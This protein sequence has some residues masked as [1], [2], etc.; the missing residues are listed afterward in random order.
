MAALA[1]SLLAHLALM[2]EVGLRGLLPLTEPELRDFPIEAHLQAPVAEPVPLPPKARVPSPRPAPGPTTSPVMPT[3]PAPVPLDGTPAA[4]PPAGEEASMPEVEPKP[5]PQ[6]APAPVL[7]QPSPDSVPPTQARVRVLP[8]ALTLVYTIRIGDDGF[9][10]GR[11]TYTWRADGDRYRL[12]SVAEATGLAALF[13]GGLATQSSEGRI[14]PAGLVPELFRMSR[15]DRR[16]E[17]A[18]F[19]WQAQR[20][21]LSRGEAS[22][23]PN[24]QDLL[25]FPFHLAMTVAEDSED[26]ILPV[27][28]GRKLKGYRFSVLGRETL[29]L[30]GQ[31][32][33]TLHVQGRRALEG[34]LDVW[35]APGRHWLPLRIRTQDQQGKIMLLSLAP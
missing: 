4:V 21:D 20:L 33:D 27:T 7:V 16:Q 3:A 1:A 9:N 18:R 22:L 35:L 31:A 12:E 8:A 24:T 28:N 32:V 26:W 25:S 11:G 14:G 34:T 23:R 13:V 2:G 29:D 5:D 19:D 17:V 6:P 10:V 15:N 30:G